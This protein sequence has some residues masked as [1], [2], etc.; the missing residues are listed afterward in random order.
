MSEKTESENRE[1]TIEVEHNFALLLTHCAGYK[2]S[3][4]RSMFVT[5]EVVDSGSAA[6]PNSGRIKLIGTTEKLSF[7][8]SRFQMR[9]IINGFREID[10]LKNVSDI[11][12]RDF[13]KD[14]SAMERNSWM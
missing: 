12:F 10:V 1:E 6:K 14:I 5:I 11:M 8:R 4:Q 2:E 7:T 13:Q 3:L 9:K